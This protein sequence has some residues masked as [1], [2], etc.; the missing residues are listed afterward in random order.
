MKTMRAI[1]VSKANAPFEIVNR[2]V[3]EPRVGEVRVKVQACGVCHSD[4][5]TKNGLFPGIHYP[6]IPG[7]EVAGVIDAVGESSPVWK[8][9]QRV[10]VGWNG[11]YCGR[12]ES[13]RRGNFFAC[14]QT[15]VTGISY[16]GGYAD[17]MLAA[18]TALVNIPAEL[19]AEEA[20]PLLCA[21]VTTYNSLRNCGAKAGDLVAVLGIGGLGHLAVQFASK[22]GFETI[23]IARGKDKESLAKQLGAVR[24]IDS[25]SQDPAQELSKLGGAKTIIATATDA[26]AMEAVIGGLS[27]YGKLM[28]LGA[29]HDPLEVPAGPLI[30]GRRSIMGWY[31]G[32]SI[33][34][35]DTLSFSVLTGVKSMNEVFPLEQVTAAYDH[36]ISGKARFRVVLKA[37]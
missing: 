27:V 36:M 18:A 3:P 34:S 32:T 12:C 21:G 13:C 24:Y 4:S 29:P 37:D 15:K 5:V 31:S 35:E 1:Q 20:A 26:K 11:G 33:D 16:D 17:Y 25:Q 6:R 30:A 22:M 14:S 9:G 2:A 10:G 23:A 19:S 28:V 8:T 7:H